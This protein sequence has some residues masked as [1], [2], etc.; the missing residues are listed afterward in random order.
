MKNQNALGKG[1]S[2]LIP[3]KI[4][5]DLQT[6]TNNFQKISI[7]KIINNP[8]QPRKKFDEAHIK[9]LAKSI[10]EYGI[11][12][13]I[14]V[15]ENNNGEYQIIAGERRWRAAQIIGISEIPAIVKESSNESSVEIS[16]IE[17][18][19]REDLNPIEEAEIY[20]ELLKKYNLSHQDIADKVGKSRSYVTNMLRFLKMPE[21]LKKM[22]INNEISAGHAKVVMASG[23][24]EELAKSIKQEN[25]S[26]RQ[27]E[28]LQKNKKQNNSISNIK[29]GTNDREIKALEYK[30]ENI[31][32]LKTS[33]R[34]GRD[35]GTITVSFKSMDDF[36]RIVEILSKPLTL[37]F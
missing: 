16:L 20:D 21:K 27:A 5:S 23:N 14:L 24:P 3:T 7:T 29:N 10:K 32:K 26:V 8:N 30:I 34:L 4:L 28:A 22:L 15:Q 19:Q 9:E 1:L 17:N 13:P 2:S 37:E 6:N 25:L 31:I 33:I 36:D 11:L 18:I 35:G 12:Q